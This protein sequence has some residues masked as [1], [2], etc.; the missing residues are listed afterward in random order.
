MYFSPNS[1]S[2]SGKTGIFTGHRFFVG[3]QK[4]MTVETISIPINSII[5]LLSFTM[6][7]ITLHIS[8]QNLNYLL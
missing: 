5:I 3:I 7:N 6:H 8:E 2:Q 1:E 4:G